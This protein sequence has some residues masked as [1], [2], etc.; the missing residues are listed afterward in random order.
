MKKV[1]EGVLRFKKDV[2][3]KHVDLFEALSA[4][5]DPEALLIT[6]S[7]SRV[8]PSLITQSE[9]GEL[10]ICRN[11]GNIV[12]PHHDHTGGV[13]ASI[14]FA[15]GALGI[16]EIIVC[17]H[18]DCGAMKGVVNPDALDGLP[19]VCNWLGHS[20]AALEVTHELYPDADEE[21]LLRRVTEQNVLLQLSHLATHPQ[22]AAGIAAGRIRMHGWVYDISQGDIWA[23]DAHSNQFIPLEE[24]VLAA[25]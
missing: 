17:G 18:T 5:Q 23:H 7:D 22:V 3:P 1:I 8:D 15:V 13:T 19:H 24:T 2:F 25:A 20:K 4:G 11:A 6:C 10:F 9:P 14:E 12:P 21:E 16:S